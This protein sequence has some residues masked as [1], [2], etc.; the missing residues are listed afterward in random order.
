MKISLIIKIGIGFAI[1]LLSVLVI[2]FINTYS[3]NIYFNFEKDNEV[4]QKNANNF[5]KLFQTQSI[6]FIDFRSNEH[7]RIRMILFDIEASYPRMLETRIYN[8]SEEV[9]GY[10]DLIQKLARE[11]VN[12][13]RLINGKTDAFGLVRMIYDDAYLSDYE[14]G[15]RKVIFDDIE[16]YLKKTKQINSNLESIY[17]ILDRE[18]NKLEGF[19]NFL[20][21]IT[22][23]FG[24]IISLIFSFFILLGVRKSLIKL[25]RFVV[26]IASGDFTA[27]IDIRSKDEIQN[28]AENIKNI[29]FFEDTLL[30]IKNSTKTLENSYKKINEA[31]NN[32]NRIIKEQEKS[33]ESA[34]DSFKELAFALSEISKNSFETMNIT[35]I[36]KEDTQK[37]SNQIK[38]TISEINLLSDFAAKIMGTVKI[39]NSITEQTELLSLN[40]AVEA[41]KAGTK[42]KGFAVVASEIGKLAE[43][44]NN[45]TTEIS[46][47]VEDIIDKIKR[48]SLKSEI[49]I[50][51]LKII[52]S[53]IENVVNKMREITNITEKESLGSK[54]IMEEVIRVN[55][56]TQK[57]IENANK[58]VES[59]KLLKDKVDELHRL[60][61]K[62]RLSISE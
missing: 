60:V 9:K 39:I 23:L 27:K 14:I 3:L 18:K 26:K 20:I 29:I 36:S 61:G 1:L 15:R 22:T 51:S 47:L 55:E 57:N 2:Y 13:S 11:I 24:I 48:T 25:T 8:T 37:S 58:I 7:F 10:V 30:K 41:A 54:S 44:S 4:F 31:V 21:N 34:S 19:R 45:A 33:V 16:S 17:K 6:F 53:S 12:D 5:N 35:L 43:M 38:D 62:F 46:Q 32:I 56:M 49:S 40:A 59:N 52:E 28:L 50:E 42:G